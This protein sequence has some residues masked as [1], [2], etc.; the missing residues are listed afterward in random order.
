D[1][2]IQNSSLSPVACLWVGNAIDQVGG[3]RHAHIFLL[4]VVPEHRRRG[5]GKALMGHVEN[6]AKA[7]GDCQIGLQV[8]ESNKAAL[9]LYNQLGYQTLSLWMV[10]RLSTDS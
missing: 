5:I 2:E 1:K 9:N 4:F 6:W 10:K 8:F 7:R 3:S